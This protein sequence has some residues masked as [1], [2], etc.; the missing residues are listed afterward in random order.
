MALP[1]KSPSSLTPNFD[2]LAAALLAGRARV[3]QESR[4]SSED[5]ALKERLEREKANIDLER[6]QL[7]NDNERALIDL[8]KSYGNN[9]ISFLWSY[10]TVA[11]VFIAADAVSSTW[12]M[13]DGVAVALVGGTAVSVLGVV[14]TIVAGLFKVK[15][16]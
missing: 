16:E 13:P 9:M 15:A 7:F 1:P 5:I 11:M 6:S 8:R 10:F 4:V 14:G 3:E 12:S 2:A